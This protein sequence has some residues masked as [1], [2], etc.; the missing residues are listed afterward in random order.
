MTTILK[1][2]TQPSAILPR[3]IKLDWSQTPLHALKQAPEAGHYINAM[4]LLVHIEFWFCKLFNKALPEIQDQTL[5]ADMKAF[6][7]QEATHA[8]THIGAREHL[9]A[10]GTEIDSFLKDYEWFFDVVLGDHNLQQYPWLKP[11]ERWW[12]NQRLSITSGL[13]HMTL[14]LAKWVLENHDMLSKAGVDQAVL[15]LL[16]WHSMEEIEHRNVAF[17]VYNQMSGNL[18]SRR[19]WGVLTLVFMFY[20]WPRGASH[21]MH[22]DPS[23]VK[24]RSRI[25][26][27]LH[28]ARQGTLPNLQSLGAFFL[29]YMKSDYHP[30]DEAVTAEILD[31]WV[32]ILPLASEWT[33]SK[34]S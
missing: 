9:A 8:R 30:R 19:F 25:T 31:R 21:F 5:V 7:R 4:H 20:W 17:D 29:N 11:L 15:D 2:A 26:T 16:I 33:P 18:A 22:Q 3:K 32:H 12:L 24:R 1:T 14:F 10:G 27:Y 23:M 28:C 34:V 13:E 6:M